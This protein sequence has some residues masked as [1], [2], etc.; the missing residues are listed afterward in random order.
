MKQQQIGTFWYYHSEVPVYRTSDMQKHVGK[1][2]EYIWREDVEKN[3]ID[4][5]TVH[6]RPIVDAGRITTAGNYSI[7]MAP[8]EPATPEAIKGISDILRKHGQTEAEIENM[9]ELMR[10]QKNHAICLSD[11]GFHS[12]K[13]VD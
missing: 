12:C 7:V 2:V 8:T 4:G 1:Y 6:R 10:N 3:G 13:V 5:A 11:L 9:A